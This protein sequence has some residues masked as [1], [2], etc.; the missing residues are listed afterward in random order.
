MK[1]ARYV[2]QRRD[3]SSVEKILVGKSDGKSPLKR[4]K[5]LPL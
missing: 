3:M 1:W 5:E 4:P 2:A